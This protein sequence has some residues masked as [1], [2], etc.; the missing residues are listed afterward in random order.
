MLMEGLEQRTMLS[1]SS[2]TD[3][4]ITDLNGY[5][6]LAEVR[7]G[8]NGWEDPGAVNGMVLA[9][10]DGEVAGAP[11]S[12]DSNLFDGLDSGWNDVRFAAN[13]AGTDRI[14]WTVGE[15]DSLSPYTDLSDSIG[16]IV[17]RAAVLEGGLGMM[18]RSVL[19]QFKR[20]GQL[21]ESVFVGSV[22]ADRRGANEEGPAESIVV[23]APSAID[24]DEVIVTGAVRMVGNPGV[25]PGPYDIAGQIFV[26]ET[27]FESLPD[28]IPD[29][30]LF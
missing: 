7:F 28:L 2:W 25:W 10:E 29:D 9:M 11:V 1:V 30:P 21:M 12:W 4:S 26:Y 15:F 22:S 3:S 23:V 16:S 19:V 8:S 5:S 18:W 13:V 24:Y 27:I 6:M 14:L 17:I 20:G